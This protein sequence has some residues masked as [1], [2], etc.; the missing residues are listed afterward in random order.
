[1]AE[2]FEDMNVS[3]D[4]PALFSPQ[5]WKNRIILRMQGNYDMYNKT[6]V[7]DIWE[8]MYCVLAL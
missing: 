2:V 1:M 8:V 5:R 4:E 7:Y 3:E 6:Q